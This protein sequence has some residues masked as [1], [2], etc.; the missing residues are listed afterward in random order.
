MRT[1]LAI[2]AALLA[3]IAPNLMSAQ[4]KNEAEQRWIDSLK[5]TPVARIETGMP[6]KPLGEWLVANAKG[7]EVRYTVESCEDFA[8]AKPK[9]SN[10]VSW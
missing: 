5:A 1:K 2:G 4:S 9:L 8:D 10:T 3:G 6:E 7:T